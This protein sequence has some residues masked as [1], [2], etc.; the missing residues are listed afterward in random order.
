[1]SPSEA[2]G[3]DVFRVYVI[4]ISSIVIVAGTVL[5]VLR[6]GL[7][8]DVTHAWKAYKGWLVIAFDQDG[9]D[10]AGGDCADDAAHGERS[11]LDEK[12]ADATNDRVACSIKI[13]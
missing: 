8:R 2:L 13:Q 11:A 1:M 6:W 10:V 5:A 9:D 4:L 12:C 7:R 3:N